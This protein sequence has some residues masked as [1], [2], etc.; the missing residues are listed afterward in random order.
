MTYQI[1]GEDEADIKVGRISVAHRS[2]AR[3]W[4]SSRATSSKSSR[5]GGK[6][7]YEIIAVRYV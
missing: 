7:S 1:V 5:P 3:W 4:A 6:R 2:R